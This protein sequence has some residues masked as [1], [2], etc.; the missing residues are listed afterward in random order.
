MLKDK[1]INNFFNSEE[2]DRML[3]KVGNDDIFSFKNNIEWL[4]DHPVSAVIFN[5]PKNI[6]KQL[7][8]TYNNSFKELV[9]G[10][11]PTEKDILVTLEIISKRLKE[12]EWNIK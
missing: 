10:E 11:F 4:K 2:F 6:W 7:K 8:N 12:V 5:Q 9:Y 3:Q 1:E